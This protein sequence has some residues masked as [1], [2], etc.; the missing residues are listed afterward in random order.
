MPMTAISTVGIRAVN[1]KISRARWRKTV[2]GEREVTK[3]ILSERPA[4][5][6]R[7]CSSAYAC[8]RETA[9][10][11]QAAPAALLKRSRAGKG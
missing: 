7:F 1:M 11:A 8:T 6:P 10:G 2:V 5:R 4:R 9:D 3:D